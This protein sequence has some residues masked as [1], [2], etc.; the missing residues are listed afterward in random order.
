MLHAVEGFDQQCPT[1][2][3]VE[4][5]PARRAEVRAVVETDAGGF[6]ELR[7]M[8]ESGFAAID[9]GKVGRFHVRGLEAGHRRDPLGHEIAI[10][11][12]IIDQR[13]PPRLAVAVGGQRCPQAKAERPF[14]QP[15]P[16]HRDV[17]QR[18]GRSEQG[19]ELLCVRRPARARER[20]P[21]LVREAPMIHAPQ[22][23]DARSARNS[24]P[25]VLQSV[26]KKVME[27]MTDRPLF[28]G[29]ETLVHA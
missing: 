18:G 28:V 8:F 12:Q 14:D 9:P 25:G 16:L 17:P 2:R 27:F 19:A 15:T 3:E 11:A 23:L 1:G 26:S 20:L 22:H 7:R 29:N 10:A 5:Y 4:A 13:E 21:Q 24:Q 6:E